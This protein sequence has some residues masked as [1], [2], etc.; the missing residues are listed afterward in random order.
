MFD[1]VL[2]LAKG[3]KTV[4]MGDS[5][6]ALE[7]FERLGFACPPHFNPAGTIDFIAIVN[8][9]DFYLD[10]ISGQVENKQIASEPTNELALDVN[11]IA[12]STNLNNIDFLIKQWQTQETTKSEL[13]T[14]LQNSVRTTPNFIKQTML[15]FYRAFLIK[16]MDRKRTLL[17]LVYFC[18]PGLAMGAAGTVVFSFSLVFNVVFSEHLLLYTAASA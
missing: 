12:P 14:D 9:I 16:F 7:Y 6:R 11:P 3:G 2:L 15:F 17:E 1:D 18:I 10:V 5:Q 8:C 4:Y 13:E